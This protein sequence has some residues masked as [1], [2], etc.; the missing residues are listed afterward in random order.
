MPTVT[1]EETVTRTKDVCDLCGGECACIGTNRCEICDRIAC[2]KC[3]NRENEGLLVGVNSHCSQWL[4]NPCNAVGIER[5]ER[6]RK[7]QNEIVEERRAWRKLGKEQA[8]AVS[9]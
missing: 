5:K 1:Y 4:C 3:G 7:L 9:A 6:I 8:K 2:F